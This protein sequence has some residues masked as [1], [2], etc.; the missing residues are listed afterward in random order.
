[1]LQKYAWPQPD[2]KFVIH[3]VPAGAHL[4]DIAAVGLMYPQVKYYRHAALHSHMVAT[5]KC[6]LKPTNMNAAAIGR[7][8]PGWWPRAGHF[9]RE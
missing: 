2:G 8:R 3:D 1:M 4:L 9:G 6:D 7:Q 5:L